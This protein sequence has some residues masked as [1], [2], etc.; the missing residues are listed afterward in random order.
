[1]KNLTIADKNLGSLNAT[2]LIVYPPFFNDDDAPL[3]TT[4]HKL[5]LHLMQLSIPTWGLQQ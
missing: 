5:K 3:Y 4:R 1:M 2:I